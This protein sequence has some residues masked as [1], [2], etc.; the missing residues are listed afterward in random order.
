MAIRSFPCT[1]L[2]WASGEVWTSWTI[3]GNTWIFNSAHSFTL[4]SVALS[5]NVSLLT[6]GTI[7]FFPM[8]FSAEFLSTSITFPSCAIS[9]SVLCGQFVAWMT[10]SPN[11]FHAVSRLFIVPLDGLPNSSRDLTVLFFTS[12]T[13]SSLLWRVMYFTAMLL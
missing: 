12:F 1:L 9:L 5:I 6:C 8:R 10:C 11:S 13:R 4:I 7:T 3:W 2:P